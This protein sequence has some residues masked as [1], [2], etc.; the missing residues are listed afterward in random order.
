MNGLAAISTAVSYNTEASILPN[1]D[2]KKCLSADTR[3]MQSKNKLEVLQTEQHGVHSDAKGS[4]VSATLSSAP[5]LKLGN[6]SPRPPAAEND[7]AESCLLVDAAALSGGPSSGVDKGRIP[8]ADEKIQNLCS[9]MSTMGLD[10]RTKEHS[11][12]V[13]QSSLCLDTYRLPAGRGVPWHDSEKLH[14]DSISAVATTAAGTVDSVNTSTEVC[15]WKSYVQDHEVHKLPSQTE[16]DFDNQRLRDAVLVKQATMS[17]SQHLLGHL[18]NPLQEHAATADA[19]DYAVNSA[20][21]TRKPNEGFET[22]VP[23]EFLNNYVSCASVQGFLGSPFNVGQENCIGGFDHG[24]PNLDSQSAMDLGESSIISNILDLDSWDDSLTSPQN[25]AKFLGKSDKSE[26]PVKLANSW[27]G[28][29]CNQS[30]FSFARQEELRNHL[31]DFES[32]LNNIVQGDKDQSF[33]KSFIENRGRYLDIIGNGFGFSQH[34]EKSDNLR[35][36]HSALQSSKLACEYLLRAHR[37]S[38]ILVLHE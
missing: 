36:S 28:Q 16:D 22:N 15:D 27:K 23:D 24:L 18:K 32:S 2:G 10:K 14:D 19:V 1:H 37:A 25:L 21:S 13:R 5:V 35:S 38:L 4:D 8:F 12:I 17:A 34:T 9:E 30:R 29:I 20:A 33:G 31:F 26:V 7:N 3:A 11:D 6:Q